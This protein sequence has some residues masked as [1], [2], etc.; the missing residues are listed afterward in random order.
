MP[1][2]QN[3][4]ARIEIVTTSVVSRAPALQMEKSVAA[5]F[6]P[7]R[8]WPAAGA[9]FPK[10]RARRPASSSSAPADCAARCRCRC[11]AHQST[12]SNLFW[13]AASHR[14]P[15]TGA[16]IEHLRPAGAA[17]EFFQ[18]HSARRSPEQPGSASSR[19]GCSVLPPSPH[20]RPPH[21]SP[22]CGRAQPTTS[23]RRDVLDLKS[24][25]EFRRLNKS[26][27]PCEHQASGKA[28]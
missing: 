23:M 11:T 7:A 12:P 3:P 21:V 10:A 22:G 28:G 27:S 9:G 18:T 8:R 15:E 4:A 14:R 1:A 5:G 24:P 6:T 13:L 19:K 26:A 20:R 17:L 25:R 2:A 16:I